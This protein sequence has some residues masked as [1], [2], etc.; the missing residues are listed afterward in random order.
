MCKEFGY[1]EGLGGG[2]AVVTAEDIDLCFVSLKPAPWAMVLI[3]AW[4][5]TMM[6]SIF[7]FKF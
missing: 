6:T 4:R 5:T 3:A 7:N 2:E 1:G